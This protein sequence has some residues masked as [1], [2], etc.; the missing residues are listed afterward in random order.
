M[1]SDSDWR[2]T[3]Q[4]RYLLGARLHLSRYRARSPLWD[5]DHCEFCLAK[6]SENSDSTARQQGYTTDDEDHW[7]CSECFR[8]FQEQFQ[9]VLCE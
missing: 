3:G 4:E 1:V 8:D 2:L 9:F 5:H 6:F 7:I